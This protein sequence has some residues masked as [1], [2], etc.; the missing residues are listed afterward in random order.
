MSI[1]A[2]IRIHRAFAGKH[3]SSLAVLILSTSIAVTQAACGTTAARP[4]PTPTATPHRLAPGA[5]ARR[6]PSDHASQVMRIR[7]EK[8]GHRLAWT[9]AGEGLV[10][11]RQSPVLID[12]TEAGMGAIRRALSNA[13][14][15][16]SAYKLVSVA[17]SLN[18]LLAL[19]KRLGANETR[20]ARRGIHLVEWGLG[21]SDTVVAYISGYNA[22]RAAVLRHDFGG[23]GW[24]TVKPQMPGHAHLDLRPA[25]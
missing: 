25:S 6:T 18:D 2:I 23:P 24:I 8:I 16:R 4:R 5:S 19:A 13:G 1:A 15:P 11:G 10:S 12:A 20:L 22:R 9:F 21:S 3:R 14:I 17:H 7:I